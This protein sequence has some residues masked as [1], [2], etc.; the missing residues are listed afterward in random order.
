MARCYYCGKKAR[1]TCSALIGRPI[2]STCCR[3]KMNAEIKC[4]PDCPNLTT[5]ARYREERGYRKKIQRLRDDEHLR[6]ALPA[7]HALDLFLALEDDIVSF[8]R[9]NPA[10]SDHNVLE[11]LDA[12]SQAFRARASGLILPALAISNIAKPLSESLDKTI[13]KHSV[14]ASEHS[15]EKDLVFETLAK[16]TA[17]VRRYQSQPTGYLGF[18]SSLR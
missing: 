6:T 8:Y 12:A 10:L 7:E 5:A 11:A 18:L 14:P 1:R 4:P 15:L 13:E 3:E 17:S 16:L 2:C 9:A